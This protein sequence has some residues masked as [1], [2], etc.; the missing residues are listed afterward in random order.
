[1]TS[2][3]RSSTNVM[4]TATNPDGCRV[5]TG[6]V[7]TCKIST[8]AS[9]NACVD[10]SAALLSVSRGE[11]AG[12]NRTLRLET[13]AQCPVCCEAKGHRRGNGCVQW[14][15]ADAH[16]QWPRKQQTANQR[17]DGVHTTCRAPNTKHGA[18]SS[19]TSRPSITGPSRRAHLSAPLCTP[20]PA[21]S[22]TK[23]TCVLETR[24][25]LALA[26][27]FST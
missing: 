14:R 18:S 27:I 5:H 23:R 19:M 15:P 6:T 10:R 1:M 12:H 20:S 16:T 13:R 3:R 11:G 24:Q 21:S 7:L 8:Q 26:D 9:R 17:N 22:R 4:W 2:T 25:M